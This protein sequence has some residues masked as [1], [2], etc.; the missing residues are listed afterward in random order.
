MKASSF[1]ERRIQY[2][3]VPWKRHPKVIVT[4]DLA[5]YGA[6][7]KDIRIEAKQQTG[8]YLNNRIESPHLPFRRVVSAHANFAEIR[9]HACFCSQP[10]QP[11]PSVLLQINLQSQTR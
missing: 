11:R 4:A 5:S 3:I 7:M 9:R 1:N 6:A 10:F 2:S 8:R